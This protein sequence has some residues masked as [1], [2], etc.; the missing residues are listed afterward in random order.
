MIRNLFLIFSIVFSVGA[1]SKEIGVVGQTYHIEEED[2]LSF[3]EHRLAFMNKNGEWEGIQK[4]VQARVS[5]HIDRPTPLTIITKTTEHRI[6]NYDPS[7]IVPYD[8]HD[9]DGNVFAK[10]GTLV[11]PLA[12]VQLHTAMLFYDADDEVQVKWIKNLNQ[13]Y[14]N[15]IKLVLVNGSVSSQEKIFHQP[16][17]FDQEGRLTSRFGIH[18]VPAIVE[19]DKLHLKISELVI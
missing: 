17:Y 10:A 6:W 18:H 3:I 15:K 11:N 16:I 8:L 12:I 19:Q 13:K 9:K 14:L 4:N 7:V 1:F 2:L 5:K